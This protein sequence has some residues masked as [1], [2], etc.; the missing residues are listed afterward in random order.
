MTR[1]R[2]QAERSAAM[3]QRLV[4]AAIAS[5]IAGGLARTTTVEICRRAGVTRGAFQHHFES[6]AALLIEVL[7]ALYDRMGGGAPVEALE[8]FVLAAHERVA[9]PEF[10]AV[11]EIWLAARNDPELGRELAPAI[12]RM[13]SRFDPGGS[14]ALAALVGADPE[15]R[16]FHRVVHEALIGLALGRAVSPTAAPVAHEDAV[17][18]WLRRQARELDAR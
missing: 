6:L 12:A 10:K 1:S 17:I 8:A 18:D 9:R 5:L 2:T 3:K 14:P 13:S 15:R 4:E 16:S 7:D 11:I